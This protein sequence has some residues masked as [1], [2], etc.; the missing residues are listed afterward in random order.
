M[1]QFPAM[2]KKQLSVKSSS[3]LPV[4]RGNR[5]L[6][7]DV[8]WRN[9]RDLSA[10][11]QKSLEEQWNS[12][13]TVVYSRRNNQL[14]ANCRDYFDRP[15]HV[16]DASVYLPVSVALKPVWLLSCVSQQSLGSQ[17]A[18]GSANIPGQLGGSSG[19]SEPQ[20]SR[21]SEASKL[22]AGTANLSSRSDWNDRHHITQSVGNLHLHDNDREYFGRFLEPKSK[23]VLQHRVNGLTKHHFP[24][25]Q[26]GQPDGRDGDLSQAEVWINGPVRPSPLTRALSETRSR[27][28]AAPPAEQQ[29]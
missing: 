1:S 3:A 20:S 26:P 13:H 8:F 16:Q 4:L 22:T 6:K 29:A 24:I 15:R 7:Q 5:T 27:N 9:Q 23:R 2:S 21:H 10:V 14:A 18:L 25:V 11:E 19:A 17:G 12:R 28:T